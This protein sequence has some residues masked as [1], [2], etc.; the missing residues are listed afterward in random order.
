[1]CL[2]M[3]LRLASDIAILDLEGKLLCG[4]ETE[5]LR[6]SLLKLFEQGHT[7]IL[8]NL[9]G[10]RHADSGGLGDLVAAYTAVTRRG[11]A[12]KVLKPHDKLLEML[13]LTHI[14]SLLDIWDDEREAVASFGPATRPRRMETLSDFLNG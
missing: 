12:I 6:E 14:D 4:R 2:E 1:M 10:V 3:K 7:R 13:R 8:L 11:G 9:E 5:T